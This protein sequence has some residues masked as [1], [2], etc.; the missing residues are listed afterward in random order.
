[1]EIVVVAFSSGQQAEGCVLNVP[2]FGLANL[3]PLSPVGDSPGPSLEK[4]FGFR[5]EGVEI[6]S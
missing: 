2:S 6:E 4:S 5:P 3:E 1:M